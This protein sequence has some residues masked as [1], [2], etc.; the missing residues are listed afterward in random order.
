MFD[1]NSYQKEKNLF[2]VVNQHYIAARNEHH[3]FCRPQELISWVRLVKEDLNYLYFIEAL[4]LTNPSDTDFDFELDIIVANLESHQ[5]LHLHVQFNK[6][7]II[8]SIVNFYPAS[9][10][11]LR[12]QSDLYDFKLDTTLESLFITQKNKNILFENWSLQEKIQPFTAPKLPYNPNKSEAPYPQESW[13]WKHGDLYSKD[14][15]GK[16]EAFY[17]LDPFKLVNVKIRLGSYFKGIESLLSQKNHKH[18][19]YL[20]EEVNQLASPFYSGAWAINIEEILK[21]EITERAKGLRI[22]LWELSRISE[23]LFVIYEMCQLLQLNESLFFLDAFERISEL[24]EG[25][26][27]S[28]YGKGM[29]KI[30]GMNFDIPA[31]W[32]IEFQAFNKLFLKNISIYHQHLI[33]NAKFRTL[34]NHHQVSSH[35]VLQYGVSGPSLRAAGINYDLRKSRP[36]YFYQDIDFDVPVG[37]HGTSFDRY[38]I[39][40]EEMIQSSRI[41]TQVLDNLPLGRID[42]GVDDREWEQTLR[43]RPKEFHYFALEAP[44][45]ETGVVYAQGENALIKRLKIKSPSLFLAQALGEF[46][47]GIDEKSI[48]VALASLGIR[49]REME[50]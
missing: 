13:R 20:L 2:S 35:S 15:L 11:A 45:G 22:V 25:L 47:K 48:P 23:H 44:N 1:H 42:L 12:E 33:S 18:I 49:E 17:C 10:F 36:L 3:I 38:L 34:I 39:R 41:I 40:Y 8:P 43:A 19:T 5:R 29:I 26:S 28:R 6:T 37:V 14:T 31:G 32:I 16:F 9:L 24:F 30:G 46:L 7:E 27:G 21:L 4:V 50:R